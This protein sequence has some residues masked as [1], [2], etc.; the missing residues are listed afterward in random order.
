MSLDVNGA[1][2]SY[3]G[4]EAKY[5]FQ[6]KGKGSLALELATGLILEHRYELTLSGVSE[7]VGTQVPEVGTGKIVI[8]ATK[9]Q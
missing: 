5:K 2:I 4:I 8:L 9:K 7:V 6:A 3:N 1:S